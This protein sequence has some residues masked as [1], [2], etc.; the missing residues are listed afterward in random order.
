MILECSEALSQQFCPFYFH[1]DLLLVHLC[2]HLSQ[3]SLLFCWRIGEHRF[4]CCSEDCLPKHLSSDF[5]GLIP[6]CI[7]QRSRIGFYHL[8]ELALPCYSVVAYYSWLSAA[9][10]IS[11][12]APISSQFERPWVEIFLTHDPYVL[13]LSASL[14]SQYRVSYSFLSESSTLPQPQILISS[15]HYPTTSNLSSPFLP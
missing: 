12:P 11:A 3:V 14:L 15:Q 1:M 13:V 2:L 5:R 6:S 9:G 8:F 7:H 10:L 4:E